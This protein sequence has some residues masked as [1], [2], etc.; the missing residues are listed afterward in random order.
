MHMHLLYNCVESQKLSFCFRFNFVFKYDTWNIENIDD[1]IKVFLK[2][3]VKFTKQS[4][5][6]WFEFLF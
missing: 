3:N 6:N 2:K 1:S 5:I 4:A